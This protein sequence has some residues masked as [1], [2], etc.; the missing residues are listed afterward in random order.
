MYEKIRNALKLKMKFKLEP[1]QT[2][3]IREVVLD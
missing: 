2:K 1:I 3:I